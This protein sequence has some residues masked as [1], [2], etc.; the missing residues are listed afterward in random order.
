MLAAQLLVSVWIIDLF[1]ASHAHCFS[2]VSLADRIG[3]V[4]MVTALPDPRYEAVS[5]YVL[6][7]WNMWSRGE[8]VRRT[9]L[10]ILM[11]RLVRV[12][13]LCII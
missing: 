7:W 3:N 4:E 9:R 13:W 1:P 11:R 12:L 6:C 2:F 8:V 10:A 5:Y